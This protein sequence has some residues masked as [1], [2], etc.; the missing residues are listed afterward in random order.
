MGLPLPDWT[1][2]GDGSI[3]FWSQMKQAEKSYRN[4]TP[5]RKKLEVHLVSPGESSHPGDACV[6]K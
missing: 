5:K 6:K 4:K 2:V 3:Y 1:K